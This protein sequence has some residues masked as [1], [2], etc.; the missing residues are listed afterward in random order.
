MAARHG[1]RRLQRGQQRG[2]RGRAVRAA[3]RAVARAAK[4][5]ESAEDIEPEEDEEEVVVAEVEAPPE[6][7]RLPEIEPIVNEP[8]VVEPQVE[9]PVPKPAAKAPSPKVEKAVSR[10]KSSGRYKAPPIKLL[11]EVPAGN[12]AIDKETLLKNA[13]VLEEAMANFD[14]AGKIVE[15]SPG[16]VVTRYE[17]EP[18]AG[19]KV[20]RISALSDDLARVMSA[21]GSR[22]GDCQSAAR[23]RL[24]ARN[25]GGQDIPPH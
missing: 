1:G 9:H 20:N 21:K 4:R 18:A 17:I 12:E 25:P 8:A 2:G 24:F 11:D 3:E 14:V 7:N 19:V 15:V 13:K 6:V 23:D 10:K 16:P 22:G 5:E